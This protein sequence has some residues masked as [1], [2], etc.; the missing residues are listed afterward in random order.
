[1]RRLRVLLVLGGELS[2]VQFRA[3][4][5]QLLEDEAEVVEAPR[6]VGVARAHLGTGGARRRRHLTR[7]TVILGSTVQY[8]M[9]ERWRKMNCSH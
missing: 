6:E 8:F 1:M 2:G 9:L 5:H 3:V 7:V 4:A